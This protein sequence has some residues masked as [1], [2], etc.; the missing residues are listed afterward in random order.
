MTIRTG[1]YT[2]KGEYLFIV[3]GHINGY[4]HFSVECC[5]KFKNRAFSYLKYAIPACALNTLYPPIDNLTHWLS[6]II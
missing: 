6:M 2:W 3:A 4:K 5:S 1:E